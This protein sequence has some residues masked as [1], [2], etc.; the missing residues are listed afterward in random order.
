MSKYDWEEGD[1]VIVAPKKKKDATKSFSSPQKTAIW[2]AFDSKSREGEQA[3]ING[4][5]AESKRQRDAFKK[6]IGDGIDAEAAFA[7]VFGKG[8]NVAMKKALSP[9]WLMS[10]KRGYDIAESM[11]KRGEKKAAVSSSWDIVNPLM[12]AWIDTNGLIRAEGINDTTEEKLRKKIA[13]SLAEGIEAG[14]GRGQLSNRI[15][16]ETDDVYEDMDRNRANLIARTETCA[17]VNFGQAETYKAEGV[18]SKEWLSTQDDRT[19]DDHVDADGQIVAIDEDFEIGGDL[20]Q[21]PGLG[22]DAS[23]NCNC[24]CTILPVIDMGD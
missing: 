24:R 6:A 3:F 13:A 4:V 14:E 16:D 8:A 7:K 9:A 17:T 15:L 23:Q 20:M 19:R 11:I 22:E 21:A 1:I 10:G 5:K 18:K 2:K 12:R